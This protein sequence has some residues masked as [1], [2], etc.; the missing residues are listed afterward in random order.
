MKPID[1]LPGSAFFD[2]IAHRYDRAYAL[3]PS[4]SRLRMEGVLR[5]LPAGAR[6]LDLGVGTGRELGA[7]QDAGHLPT[8]LDF[9]TEMLEICRRRARPVPLVHADLWAPLPFADATF[10]AV[11]ALHGTLAHPE[12]DA[13]LGQLPVE[14]SRILVPGGVLVAE[15]PTPAF[16]DGADET[17]RVGLSLRRTGVGRCIHQDAVARV[18]IEAF[19][20]EEAEWHALLGPSFEVRIEPMSPV[21]VRIVGYR[22]V[23]R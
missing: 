13:A 12:N 8:G 18:A 23:A 7:L 10:D 21:E 4:V 17:D 6:V 11:I 16:L 20:L 1:L 19:V 5:A 2:A 3:P 15:V 14:L 9:S 22:R